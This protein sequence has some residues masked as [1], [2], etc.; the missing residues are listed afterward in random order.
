[1]VAGLPGAP[2]GGEASQREV[3]GPGR[4]AAG[5]QPTLVATCTCKAGLCHCVGGCRGGGGE[6]VYCESGMRNLALR[7]ECLGPV[8]VIVGVA[9]LPASW[10]Q[11]DWYVTVLVRFPCLGVRVHSPPS[12]A[13]VRRGGGSFWLV[14]CGSVPP[15]CALASTL[16]LF[17]GWSLSCRTFVF[18][19]RR[20]PLPEFFA[21]WWAFLGNQ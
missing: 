16:F 12:G 4:K 2:V 21:G 15:M 13:G 19:F 6:S 11:P 9:Q 5:L 1:M 7:P 20:G 3:K 18:C 14:A 17:S 10:D 8:V